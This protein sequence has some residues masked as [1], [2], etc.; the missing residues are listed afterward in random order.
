MSIGAILGVMN[1][2]GILLPSVM[3]MMDCVER[4]LGSGTGVQ[5]KAIVLEGAQ[6]FLEGITAVSTGGQK[7]SWDRLAGPISMLIDILS[8]ILFPKE[9]A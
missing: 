6:Y 7:E 2:I 1:V 8:T 9:E 3:R 4:I 5:K